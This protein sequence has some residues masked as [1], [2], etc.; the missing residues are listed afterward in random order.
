MINKKQ[1]KREIKNL[2]ARDGCSGK[3]IG[4]QNEFYV[5]WKHN[6]I[7]IDLCSKCSPDDCSLLTACVST[8]NIAMDDINDMDN[9]IDTNA[10]NI[11]IS[12]EELDHELVE[13]LTL[14]PG[15]V[16]MQ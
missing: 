14:C 12:N 4:K 8:N 10:N 9:N 6:T 3:A 15:D 16:V 2:K 1:C 5:P 7:P 11:E 13:E